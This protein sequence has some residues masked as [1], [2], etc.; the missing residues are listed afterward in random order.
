M[1][2]AM[3]YPFGFALAFGFAFLTGLKRI[4]G[5]PI[6]ADCDR[7]AGRVIGFSNAIAALAK[8]HALHPLRSTGW[9]SLVGYAWATHPSPD[10]RLSL[11]RRARRSEAA[12]AAM[13]ASAGEANARQKHDGEIEC[14]AR[15][16]RL[17]R[18]VSWLG[19][20]LWA[21]ALCIGLRLASISENLAVGVFVSLALFPSILLSFAQTAAA[22][23][24]RARQRLRPVWF[25]LAILIAIVALIYA[26]FFIE[27]AAGADHMGV[28]MFLP[29]V[30][31][32][33]L[34][35]VLASSRRGQDFRRQITE[36]MQDH[37][38]DDILDIGRRNRKLIVKR[39]L[40]RY[41]VAFIEAISGDRAFAMAELEE[42]RRRYRRFAL[43][44]LTLSALYYDGG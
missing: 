8:V 23:R 44:A 24:A 39:P 18:A 10:V 37:R 42:M 11:L 14:S 5:R 29:I 12:D 36:A 41:N 43:P 38:F 32:L 3:W 2:V 35:S 13:T 1:L 25:G 7:R 22:R 34:T 31:A 16:F 21:S 26:P 6:E 40:D 28:A 27:S 15:R 19:V 20:L 17:H 4:V 30:V 9:L 33:V